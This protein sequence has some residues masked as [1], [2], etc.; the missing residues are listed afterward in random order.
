MRLKNLIICLML[1]HVV[2][3]QGVHWSG[4]L[5]KSGIRGASAKGYGFDEKLWSSK[6]LHQ[7][8]FISWTTLVFKWHSCS[9]KTCVV[10]FCVVWWWPILRFHN[11]YI[12]AQKIIERSVLRGAYMY[13]VGLSLSVKLIRTS[14]PVTTSRTLTCH[15]CWPV[16][17]IYMLM[18]SA[19]L[20][21]SRTSSRLY[22]TRRCSPSSLASVKTN[23]LIST[24]EY[25]LICFW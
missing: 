13:S 10:I 24:A 1:L 16:P 25:N 20:D 7:M 9:I 4:N 5:Q 15:T 21:E 8:N 12:L 3:K 17:D 2:D 11:K 23:P 22:A 18:T 6:K 19:T 14:S